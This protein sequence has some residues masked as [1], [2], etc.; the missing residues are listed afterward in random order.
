[1]KPSSH[2]LTMLTLNVLIFILAIAPSLRSEEPPLFHTDTGVKMLNEESFKNFEKV[3]K[4][5]RLPFL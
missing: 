3:M 4:E 5:M 2:E 1:M